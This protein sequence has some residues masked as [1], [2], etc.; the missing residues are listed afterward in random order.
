[1]TIR[2]RTALSVSILLAAMAG[3][4]ATVADAPVTTELADRSAQRG[5]SPPTNVG[6]SI[7]A[8]DAF[9]PAGMMREARW[10]HG[11]TPLLDG[12][13]LVTGTRGSD[14]AE[15]YDP[16]ADAWIGADTMIGKRGCHTATLLSDGRVLVTGGSNGDAALASAELFDPDTGTWSATASMATARADH[17]ATLLADGRV[18]VAGGFGVSSA[19]LF[20][21]STGTWTTAGNMAAERAYFTATLLADGRVLVAGGFGGHDRATAEVFDP[22]TRTWTST[23][24][25]HGPRSGHAAVLLDDGSVLVMGGSSSEGS[26]E[27]ASAT[28]RYEPSSSSWVPSTPMAAARVYLTATRMPDGRVLVTGGGARPGAGPAIHALA[29]AE[30]YDPST[31]SWRPTGPMRETRLKHRAT[32]LPDG[33]VLVTGGLDRIGPSGVSATADLYHP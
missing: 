21:P 20:D 11:A 12:R 33:D 26:Y 13:V 3:G 32:L 2:A 10:G 5:A 8:A 17:T 31:G 29:S 25:M 1:M 16:A 22:A 30:V 15:V 6:D 7:T 23:A 24:S 9:V 4:Q 18:L 27:P 28:E 14:T 19:E